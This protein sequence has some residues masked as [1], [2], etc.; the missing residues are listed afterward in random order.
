M[1]EV[2][3]GRPLV[4][5]SVALN[6]SNATLKC[7]N[8]GLIVYSPELN[9]LLSKILNTRW[10]SLHICMPIFASC[11][12]HMHHASCTELLRELREH[13]LLQLRLAG[14]KACWLVQKKNSRNHLLCPPPAH[15]S[16]AF[17]LER[18]AFTAESSQVYF[19]A[20]SVCSFSLSLFLSR[21]CLSYS[22]LVFL[23][24]Q[25]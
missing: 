24:L 9:H 6:V 22:H 20:F 18:K 16:H 25:W 3:I 4:V 14:W 11:C 12:L 15:T 21:F 23:L 1:Q 13:Y 19:C 7:V 8:L 5:F 2:V 17:T 10:W